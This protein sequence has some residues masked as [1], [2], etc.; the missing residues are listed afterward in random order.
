M[1]EDL[2]WTT[3]DRAFSKLD[4]PEPIPFRLNRNGGSSFLFWRV[5]FTR[6]GVHFA[7]KR[8]RNPHVYCISDDLD[9]LDGKIPLPP[10]VNASLHPASPPT[11]D[12]GGGS[13]LCNQSPVESWPVEGRITSGCE[14][15]RA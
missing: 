14:K 3:L 7:R 13:Y 11:A 1:A 5:F 8:S 15:D 9:D 6:T 2:V 10:Y 4:D 12:G